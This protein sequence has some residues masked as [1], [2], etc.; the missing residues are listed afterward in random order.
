[1]RSGCIYIYPC[2]LFLK[3]REKDGKS[4]A[5]LFLLSL[6]VAFVFLAV[7]FA[8]GSPCWTPIAATIFTIHLLNSGV[9]GTSQ[10]CHH[11]T[12]QL[13]IVLSFAHTLNVKIVWMTHFSP[14]H[15]SNNSQFNFIYTAIWTVWL[16][17]EN[18]YE[19]GGF[20][21]FF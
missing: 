2:T 11:P 8:R 9:I 5:K 16:H 4:F 10:L 17:D 19:K 12:H 6:R 3:G 21:V 14:L 15:D 20:E 13:F 7:V 1:M 18:P